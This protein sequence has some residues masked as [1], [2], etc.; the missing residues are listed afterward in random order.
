M[1]K[2]S[3]ES[4]VLRRSAAN[5]FYSTAAAG[6]SYRTEHHFEEAIVTDVI[7]NDSH[8][9]YSDDGYNVGVITCRLLGSEWFKKESSL[10]NAFPMD[11]NILEYPLI[12]E[13]VVVYRV[14][15]RLYYTRKLN[16]SNRVTAQ[17]LFGL[18]EE[19]GAGSEQDTS[20]GYY[21]TQATSK[22][23]DPNDP[24]KNTL[25]K[26]FKDNANVFRLRHQ[27]GDL[28]I[29]GRTG[30]SIR[31]GMNKDVSPQAPNILLRVGQN[32]SAPRT[33]NTQFGL[34]VEDVNEDKTSLWMVTNQLI[35]I[36]L[37]TVGNSVHFKSVSD[38]P[39]QFDGNQLLMNSDRVIIN[40]KKDKVFVNS[41]NG[42]HLT[43]LGD[44]T[45]DADKNY[46]SFVTVDR[47]I[48]TGRDYVLTIGRDIDVTTKQ[49][50]TITA[51][52]NT[53]VTSTDKIALKAKKIFIGT[54]HDNS[55]PLVLGDT[56]R[57]F[58]IQ[59]IDSQLVNAT[60]F[61]MTPTG[62]GRLMPSVVA[63]L[64]RLKSDLSRGKSS[65]ILSQDNF[66]VRNN[67][68]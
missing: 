51:N 16:I 33:K 3:Y 13:I 34:V 56:L 50:I 58:L 35:P 20:Q 17:P 46:I 49:N 11:A 29:E 65:S 18:E 31:F 23:I 10:V 2:T 48:E 64:Q 42:I 32:P 43:S 38:A 19:L 39:A 67:Q 30:N 53:V 24:Q 60:A 57:N 5:P 40:T 6:Q 1:F 61:V 55:E 27:E 63:Q 25:G 54:D 62:T 8:P 7:V 15:N 22:K 21:Q 47:K 68:E 44:I 41:F 14:L 36:K 26:Y 52:K 12:N 37:S 66:V 59:L 4:H 9:D 28:V 45:A